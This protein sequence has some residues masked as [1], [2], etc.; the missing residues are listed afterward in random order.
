MLTPDGRG[1]GR[2]P[3]LALP[4]FGEPLVPEGFHGSEASTNHFPLL[5]PNLRLRIGDLSPGLETKT[6]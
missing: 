6:Y 1:N 3:L 2:V 4:D 5:F